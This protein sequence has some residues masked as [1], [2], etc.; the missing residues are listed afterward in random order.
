VGDIGHRYS[1]QAKGNAEAEIYIY[2]DVGDDWFGGV[3]AKQFA[4]DLK[5]L[6]KV[7]RIS[8]RINS[9]GGDVFQGL[10]IYRLLVDHPAT[11]VAHIDGMAA[12]IASVIAMAATEINIAESAFLMIHNAWG[13][14]IGNADDMRTMASL[15]DKTTGSIR[16]VYVART[17][18]SSDQV[19]KW[20]DAETWFTAQD[21]VDNGFATAIS[22]NMKLAARV[23][24][25]KHRFQKLPDAMAATPN[26]D[27]MRER[28]ARMKA[29]YDRR[30]IAA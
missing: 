11:V 5:A 1:M 6:G 16:D 14:A 18:K 7:D 28:L 2:G 23:D 10:T 8:L 3:T 12:S 27:S 19:K 15:L 20:M 25:S 9:A 29:K 22:A 17:G 4:D 26:A 30:A 13:F 21:A 24:L